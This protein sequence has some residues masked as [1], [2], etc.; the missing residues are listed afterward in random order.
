VVRSNHAEREE[1]LEDGEKETR[2][3]GTT[4]LKTIGVGNLD[5]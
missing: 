4:N 3:T 1:I 5:S 2:L